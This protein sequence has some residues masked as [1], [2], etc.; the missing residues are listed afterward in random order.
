MPYVFSSVTHS[1]FF[2]RSLTF[3]TCD[4][5]RRSDESRWSATMIDNYKDGEF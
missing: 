5:T 4:S 2:V 1:G 3:K